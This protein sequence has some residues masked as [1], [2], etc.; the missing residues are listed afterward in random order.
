MSQ[1]TTNIISNLLKLKDYVP[2]FQTII[3][4]IF[5]FIICLIFKKSI[6]GIITILQDRIKKGSSVKVGSI[7]IGEE[8]KNIT[9]E[10]QV[11]H[12]SKV[13]IG[14]DGGKKRITP[15]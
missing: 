11:E 14:A 7:E 10:E 13:L 3:W 12:S 2:L 4:I 5:I 8:L 9:Y 1:D 15:N 6:Y